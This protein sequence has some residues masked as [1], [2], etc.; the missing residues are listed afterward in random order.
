MNN[1]LN[2]LD[3]DRYIISKELH[4]T[5]LKEK[6]DNDKKIKKSSEIYIVVFKVLNTNE[7]SLV[8]NYMFYLSIFLKTFLTFLIY[9]NVSNIRFNK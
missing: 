5:L 2:I 8:Y 3:K 7:K 9:R 4:S 6:L 1:R